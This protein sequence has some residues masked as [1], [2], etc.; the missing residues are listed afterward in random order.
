MGLFS[1]KGSTSQ[2]A[3]F[4]N[5][6]QK[7]DIIINSIDD[8]VVLIDAGNVIHVFNPSSAHM[9]G[10]AQ[11]EAV[12]LDYRSILKFV[13]EKGTI[14]EDSAHP[15]QRVLSTGEALR[16]NTAVISQKDGKQ[17]SV[18]VSVSP[19]IDANKRPTGAVAILRDVQEQRKQDKQ[20]ADFI[21]TASH[22]MRTPV[23]A[24]EGYLA[25]ALN[26]KVAQID[27]KARSYLEKAHASTQHLGK[28]FQD[29]LTSARAEDGRLTNHPTVVE[30]GEFT[31]K[32]VEDLKFTAEKKGLLLELLMGSQ[33]EA[34]RSIDASK[35][36]VRPLLYASVDADRFREV[37]TNLFD[38]AVKYTESGKIS[39]GI[40]GDNDVV[41]FHITDTGPGIPK[42][43]LGH[44]FQK[45][46]RVDNS[47]TRT[48][49][50]TGLGLYICKKIIDLY[51]GRIWVE[52]E[53]GKGS[54][55]YINIPRLSSDKARTM[56]T[57]EAS[58][59]PE[60]QNAKL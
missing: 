37:I 55:F 45:F 16:D 18:D 54:T 25:L 32:L 53:V 27:V 39:V 46:Y 42:E 38:N 2:V 17:L 7:A 3:S 6:K 15:F 14:I 47:A 30:M 5:E 33:S 35:K 9:T 28:L 20:R 49:G 60:I 23:A 12:G 24:I 31:E 11:A 43:D 34:S 21:S 19:L 52:S 51:S 13:D 26:D 59:Q 36:I 57:K 22:E 40:T 4:Q 1:K 50:G 58:A 10:W 8:G 48:I 41:Q 56:L 29:L 44:L